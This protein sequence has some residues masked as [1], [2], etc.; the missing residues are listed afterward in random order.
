MVMSYTQLLAREFKDKLGPA[1]NQFIAYAVEGAQRMEMLLRDLREFWAVNEVALNHKVRVD[2]E[3]VLLKVLDLLAAP[4]HEAGAT[5]MRD[6]MPCVLAEETPLTL[7]FQNL[8]SNAVKYRRRDVALHIHVS[9]DAAAN[10]CTV[11]VRDN[12]LG[13]ETEHLD[14]IFAPFKR[15]QSAAIPGSGLG[16]AICRRVVER[17]GGRIWVESEYGLG[18]TFRFTLPKEAAT[19]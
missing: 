11:S 6:P 16:L 8:V 19:L 18:S 4:I 10:V 13:I 7:V 12:G 5:V 17:Y 2:C 14:V 15:L 9:A 1:A 3:Q